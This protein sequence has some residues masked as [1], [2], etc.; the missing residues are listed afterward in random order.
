MY[1]VYI[2]KS[3][4]DKSYY[5]GCTKN[6]NQ[7]LKRHNAGK[8]KSLRNRRPLEIVYKED[9]TSATEAF[10]REKKIKSYKGGVAFKKL[11]NGGV[12]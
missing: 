12:A 7:R 4:V 2:L 3:K 9:Y 10:A 8:T 6:L 1:Y 11:I 5:I